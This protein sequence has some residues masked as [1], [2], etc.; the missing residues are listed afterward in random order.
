[1]SLTL[2]ARAGSA[3]SRGCTRSWCRSCRVGTWPRRGSCMAESWGWVMASRSGRGFV[4]TFQP[5]G[6]PSAMLYFLLR[7][8]WCNVEVDSGA[9]AALLVFWLR[10]CCCY[11]A[12]G[13]LGE[14]GPGVVFLPRQLLFPCCFSAGMVVLCVCRSSPRHTRCLPRQVVMLCEKCVFSPLP[15]FPS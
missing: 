10:C 12:F 13:E 5:R 1:M 15:S 9:V 7:A 8:S 4:S 11:V 2:P 6:R 14:R 3:A